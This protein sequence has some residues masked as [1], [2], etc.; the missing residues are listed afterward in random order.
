MKR[1]YA[2]SLMADRSEN[3]LKRHQPSIDLAIEAIAFWYTPALFQ[4]WIAAKLG[5]P[6]W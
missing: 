4:P 2:A 5:S 3:P 6:G 1:Q